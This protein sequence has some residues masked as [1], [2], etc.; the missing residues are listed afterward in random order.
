MLYVSFGTELFASL[1]AVDLSVAPGLVEVWRLGSAG[2]DE[3]LY[4]IAAVFMLPLT[5]YLCVLALLY[6]RKS[7]VAWWHWKTA[8]EDTTFSERRS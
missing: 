8:G 5:C 2:N 6:E 7:F 1:V 3:A 4:R